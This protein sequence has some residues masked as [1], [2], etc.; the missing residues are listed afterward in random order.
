ME[1][2]TPDPSSGPS[3]EIPDPSLIPVLSLQKHSTLL[4]G[5]SKDKLYTLQP[6][7]CK[8]GR[9]GQE[10]AIAS[11]SPFLEGQ[12]TQT[13]LSSQSWHLLTPTHLQ[14]SPVQV[15]ALHWRVLCP[16]GLCCLPGVSGSAE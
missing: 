11:T 10:S 15:P 8:E 14:I 3:V 6:G 4:W 1:F 16:F 5:T 13:A 7:V 12:G 2:R 9:K